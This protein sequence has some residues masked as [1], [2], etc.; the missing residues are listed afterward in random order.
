M[1]V[2]NI[3][4]NRIKAPMNEELITSL[5]YL[6]RY[7]SPKISAPNIERKSFV[8]ITRP[9]LN[10]SA[11]NLSKDR[12]LA[13]LNTLNPNSSAFMLRCMLDSKT[14][15]KY[16]DLISRSALIDPWYAWNIPLSNYITGISGWPDYTV[17]TETTEGGYFSENQTYVI[18]SDRLYRTYNFNLSF[19]DLPNAPI[20]FMFF[21][22][23]Y[24]M[25]A[26]T[27]GDLHPYS[28]YID[29]RRLD[30]TVSIYQFNTDPTGTYITKWAKA[31]GC[32]PTA[33]P[34]G[35]VFSFSDNNLLNVD[36][37]NISI[38]FTVNNVK[39]MDYWRLVEFNLL[40]DRYAPGIANSPE[41]DETHVDS[42]N[43]SGVPY[44][45]SSPKGFRLVWKDYKSLFTS[46]K[47]VEYEPL[48]DP[49][50]MPTRSAY[51][52]IQAIKNDFTDQYSSQISSMVGETELG[53]EPDGG[54]TP[55]QDI[56][57]TIK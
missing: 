5:K 41:I 29:G 21:Y 18:G 12:I 38:P 39:Y 57:K 30:Y 34:L 22:W 24:Y 55:I 19:R 4:L 23:I 7:R 28:Y 10:L 9:S 6:D 11:Y 25:S 44:I 14:Y 51:K 54:I 35:D 31:T 27:I 47:K 40:S 50:G 26:V 8:F 46:H 33:V 52:E 36:Y 45:V 37:N 16:R 17:E 13:P 48:V 20:L 53:F 15:L 2:E 32:F 56:L 1:S 43:Y 3:R 49:S 42:F